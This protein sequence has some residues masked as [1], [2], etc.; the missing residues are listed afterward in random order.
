M[1]L[2]I[3]DRDGVINYDSD[4]YIKDPNEWHPLPGSLE[5]IARLN[6]A[7]FRVAVASNQSGLGRGLYTYDILEE[8]HQK[9]YQELA[10]H[11]GHI[12]YMAYCPHLPEDECE[13]RKPKPG[14]LYEIEQ[15]LQH[16]LVNVPFI[17]DKWSDVAAARAAQAQ[18]VL[19]E[20][21]YGKQTIEKHQHEIKGISVFPD[22]ETYVN[23][24][25]K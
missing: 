11:G 17:G 9:F 6:E 12:D 10:A 20:T 15:E 4:D 19:V 5:A 24:L 25:L 13:C 21:G 7:G 3:L 1:A 16:S 18:P 8:I 14:L 23:E 22:L 2:I